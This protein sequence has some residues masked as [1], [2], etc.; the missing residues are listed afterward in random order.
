MWLKYNIT[1]YNSLSLYKEIS[2][3][4]FFIARLVCWFWWLE[5]ACGIVSF[6]LQKEEHQ[7]MAAGYWPYCNTLIL[8]R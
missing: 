4:V 3:L 1:N 5:K 2:F 7:V 6:P 8:G